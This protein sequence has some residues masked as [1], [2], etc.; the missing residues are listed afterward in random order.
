MLIVSCLGVLSQ[1]IVTDRPAKQTVASLQQKDGAL[2]QSII[3]LLRC[4]YCT[5]A[6]P[7][8]TQHQH[9]HNKLT[10]TRL[11][12]G[13]GRPICYYIYKHI[14]VYDNAFLTFPRSL[15]VGII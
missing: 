5:C 6:Q 2:S 12:Y 8:K 1:L 11:F 3:R 9:G 4:E 10:I 7:G 14:P 15:S 13:T